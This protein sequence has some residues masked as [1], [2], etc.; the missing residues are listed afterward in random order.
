MTHD[1]RKSKTTLTRRVMTPLAV[2]S[3]AA[4][5]LLVAPAAQ[6]N[7]FQDAFDRAARDFESARSDVE[8]E[9]NRH[10]DRARDDIDRGIR[11]A[12]REA[13]RVRNDFDRAA[14]DL[15][16]EAKRAEKDLEEFARQGTTAL[17]DHRERFDQSIAGVS[18][19]GTNFYSRGKDL[20]FLAEGQS[21]DLTKEA[22]KALNSLEAGKDVDLL[23]TFQ[24][25]AEDFEQLGA[26]AEQV[27]TLAAD[28]SEILNAVN[29]N[30]YGTV[31]EKLEEHGVID[32]RAAI[33]E[34]KR[35]GILDTEQLMAN[36]DTGTVTEVETTLAQLGLAD[37]LGMLN[38]NGPTRD[39]GTEHGLTVIEDRMATGRMQQLRVQTDSVD[40]GQS[41]PGVNVL[42]PADYEQNP[43]K[44][45]PV[46]YLN[47]GGVG[48]FREYEKQGIENMSDDMIIVMPDGG[49]GGWY[50][51]AEAE[52]G[53]DWETFHTE[54]LP[55][56]IDQ[57]Y[58]TTGHNGAGGFSM[59]GYGAMKY[60]AANPDKYESVTS[61]SGPTDIRD[62]GGIVTH[63]ANL[64]GA[65]DNGSITGM[66][67]G[68]WDE[69]K[70]SAANP[71]EN[72]DAFRDKR[73]SMF[74]GKSDD[75]TES[76]VRSG[77]DNFSKALDD[78]GVEHNYTNFDGPHHVRN[79]DLRSEVEETE[80]YLRSKE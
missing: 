4:S 42:L 74:S 44:E 71:I 69:E 14:N 61:F 16:R 28:A 59:G 43:D 34:L 18:T 2:V 19:A 13:N 37:T 25:N 70:V 10:V 21:L 3:I 79:K 65:I 56:F 58:R 46:M 67:G 38:D 73:V 77:H 50:T 64:S 51:D 12:E 26:D 54:E 23:E 30:D 8:D 45:Y 39:Y 48:N 80:K 41:G 40:W 6:A 31:V 15:N 60:T 76:S 75:I 49:L 7:P 72:V 35:Q 29:R 36:L 5:S 78:A 68:P 1:N 17:E 66:Y 47:H 24:A 63:W 27:A 33:Q 32:R 62:R 55:Q 9:V 20:N 52:E 53:N 11:D 57:N 22:Q